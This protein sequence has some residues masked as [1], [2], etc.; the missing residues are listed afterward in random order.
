MI[1]AET[2]SWILLLGCV[3]AIGSVLAFIAD[4]ITERQSKQWFNDKP[5]AVYKLT[6]QEQYEETINRR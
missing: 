2:Y 5:M 6:E 1:S 4:W 3:C